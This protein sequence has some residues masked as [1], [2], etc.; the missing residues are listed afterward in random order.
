MLSLKLP[1]RQ[2]ACRRVGRGGFTLIELLVVI[3]I[4]AILA[5]MLLPALARAKRQAQ[6]AHCTS[7]LKQLSVGWY[8]YAG[9]YNEVMLPNAP[10]SATVEKSWC[11]GAA[12]QWTHASYAS[13]YINS[14]M[15]PYVANGLGVYKCPAD[16][17]PSADGP[18]IRSYSMNSQV[19]NVYT[20]TLTLSYNPGYHAY[21]KMNELKGD[22]GPAQVF[23]FCEENMCSMNDGYLQVNDGSPIWPDVPGS[24]HIWNCGFSYADGHAESHKWLTSSLK[25]PV[26]LGYTADSIPAVGGI[27][28][29]DYI[30]WRLHTA[31][32]L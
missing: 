27:N 9:D 25:I 2:P 14:I 3:A 16:T 1:A 32:P 30:W 18:R 12:E 4:I 31:G 21:I 17:I 11:S 8:A 19:G 7:N 26:R 22:W 24:Y 13:N 15:A 29:A 28:N 5:A 23:V 6:I 10:L 20:A